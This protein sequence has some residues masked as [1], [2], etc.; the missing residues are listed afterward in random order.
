MDETHTKSKKLITSHIVYDPVYR[1]WAEEANARIETP[2]V[3]VSGWGR[4]ERK[5]GP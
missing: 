2:S 1:R 4:G 5:S 3:F